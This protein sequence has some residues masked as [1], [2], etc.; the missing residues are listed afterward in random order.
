MGFLR[1]LVG[2]RAAQTNVAAHGRVRAHITHVIM[3]TCGVA[4]CGVGVVPARGSNQ[5]LSL[6]RRANKPRSGG[7]VVKPRSRTVY[8]AVAADTAEAAA[9]TSSTRMVTVEEAVGLVYPSNLRCALQV[10]GQRDPE[11][12]SRQPPTAPAGW[13]A[14]LS[15]LGRFFFS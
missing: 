8:R 14:T 5:N 4:A 15:F 10:R 3:S 13:K 6:Q 9:E 1:T 7:V 11:V 12:L 2:T